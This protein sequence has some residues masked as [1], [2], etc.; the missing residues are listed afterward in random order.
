MFQLSKT[1]L[2]GLLALTVFAV[3]FAVPLNAQ[4]ACRHPLEFASYEQFVTSA[5]SVD[6][7]LFTITLPMFQ[8]MDAQGKPVY[9]IVTDSSNCHDATVRGVNHAPKMALLLDPNTKMPLSK[10]VQLATRDTQG[11]LHFSGTVDFSPIRYYVP[12][13]K[14]FP[15]TSWQP[16]SVGDA[17]YS[18]YVT[19]GDGIV[20]NAPQVANTTGIK[21]FV[22]AIDFTKMT[23]TLQLVHGIYDSRFLM[24][25]RMESSDPQ[26][27]AFEGG[28]WAPNMEL[29]PGLGNRFYKDG[30]ARQVILP[31]VNGITGVD[32]P[33]TRQGLE[34]GFRGD[35]DPLNI[36]GAVPIFDDPEYSPL[37]DLTPVVWTDA[38]VKGG[39]VQRMKVDTDVADQV[40]RGNMVSLSTDPSLPVNA[41]VGVRALG[42]LSNCPV[43][44]R[45]WS[46]LP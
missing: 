40:A 15:A 46:P 25:L 5:I 16:G 13:P 37:W 3:P 33:D 28:T 39:L 2:R 20:I 14:G 7:T 8:G 18:P 29:A 17:N 41:D 12:G 9:Y 35:G 31:V 1:T 27:A 24:Y 38:A 36:L 10:A 45:L 4:I 30:S 26:V 19:T 34:S 21:D 23:V 42:G 22:Y 44:L 43:M 32:H 6:L 11:L